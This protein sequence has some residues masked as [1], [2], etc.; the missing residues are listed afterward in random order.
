MEKYLEKDFWLANLQTVSDLLIAWFTSPQFYAQVGAVVAA[1][2]LA[3]ILSG[4]IYNKVSWFNQ[5][6]D[7]KSKLS[8]VRG[9]FYAVRSLL[10]PAL[11]Y[12][13]LGVAAQVV[14]SIF[15]AD[16]LIRIARSISVVYLIYRAIDLFIKHPLVRTALLYI[17]IPIAT[18]QAF[19][20]LD[21]TIAF[22][23]GIQFAAG[24]IRISVYF[25]IKTAIVGGFFFW[26]GSTS[27]KSGQN[28]IRSQKTLDV[29]T[30]ELIA[31]LFQ[32]ILFAVIF[33]LALQVL[34]LDLTAVTVFGG[35][36]AV[37]I[38]FGLQ[39]IASNF[40]SGIILLIERN[41]TVGDYIELEDGRGGILKELNMRSTTLETYDGKEIMVPN[42]KF[43]T[44]V[45][46]NWTRDDPRQRYEV[47]FSVSYDTDITN[48]PEM[49][50]QAALKHPKVLDDPEMPDCELR[51]F[52]DSG[53]KFALEFWIEGI[54]DGKNRISADLLTIIWQTLRENGIKIPY[55]QREVRVISNEPII[56]I[57][58]KP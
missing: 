36:L 47:E 33:I 41:L 40:I 27:N 6:P 3:K 34:G 49:I 43:I 20:W 17:C 37:G 10:F 35:A 51:E 30:Q 44:G 25:L 12:I 39:Q 53:I 48:L 29:A 32:I 23:D 19:G 42:E 5:A 50:V 52:G 38:G 7:P 24:N 55:P 15:G 21:E 56:S 4:I 8:K 54:D 9:Y 28:M 58:K 46:I 26:L 14:A 57:K 18:L 22:L 16:W 2:F 1:I 11:C 13:L 31:K 45:F